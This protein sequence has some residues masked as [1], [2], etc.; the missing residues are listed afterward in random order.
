MLSIPSISE[1]YRHTIASLLKSKKYQ[2]C[3]VLCERVLSCQPTS[4]L[5]L[6]N[7]LSQHSQE[8]SQSQMACTQTQSH[9]Q[10]F[11]FGNNFSQS[12]IKE[13]FT[14]KNEDMSQGKRKRMPSVEARDHEDDDQRE[15]VFVHLYKAE[16]Q[17]CLNKVKEAIESLDV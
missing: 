11:V 2:Q 13:R 9:S 8:I 12:S 5:D 6:S 7:I 14:E 15:M 4:V 1:I 3:E 10:T 17:V 16:A